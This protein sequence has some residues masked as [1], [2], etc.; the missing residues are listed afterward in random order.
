ME[1]KQKS[2]KKA[3][4][5]IGPIFAVIGL[6]LTIVGF[7]NFFTTLGDGGFPKLFFFAFI[8]LPLLGIGA[9]ITFTA[10]R[11]EITKYYVK[12]T[13]PILNQAAKDISPAIQTMTHAVKDGLTEKL[14]CACGKENDF[15]DKYC[16]EC[17]APLV[18][19][20]PKCNAVLDKD[21]KFCDQCGEKL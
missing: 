9:G 19:L 8:G 12:E 10:F 21:A 15:T 5:I 14:V 3:L 11:Q 7:V 16:A 13:A 17:G 6:T 4:K 18:P 2:I 1:N 20:C